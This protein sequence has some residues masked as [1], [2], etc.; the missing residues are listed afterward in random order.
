MPN[1]SA[2]EIRNWLKDVTTPDY[3]RMGLYRWTD[4]DMLKT[5][6]YDSLKSEAKRI[7]REQEKQAPQQ[8]KPI[9]AEATKA[10]RAK[11]IAESK[12]QIQAMG[13]ALGLPSTTS[14]GEVSMASILCNYNFGLSKRI[15]PEDKALLSAVRE[16]AQTVL[17]S[18]NPVFL[19]HLQNI[20]RKHIIER[21]G[22]KM[23]QPRAG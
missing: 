7:V 3:K 21:Y 20:C 19:E 6:V 10:A 15:D 22:E 17:D 8:P 1:F 12:H 9:G 16:E 13:E 18:L 23:L 2:E 11:E 5:D 14:L 4:I